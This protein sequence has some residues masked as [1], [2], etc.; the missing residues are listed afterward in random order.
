MFEETMS[1]SST[2]PLW[3]VESFR[4]EMLKCS[5]TILD[6]ISKVSSRIVVRHVRTL[7]FLLLGSSSNFDD[8]KMLREQIE[9]AI[10]E[11]L[12]ERWTQTEHDWTMKQFFSCRGI[13]T[14]IP[15][16]DI[17]YQVSHNQ[18]L[19]ILLLV[20]SMLQSW[21]SIRQNQQ[22]EINYEMLVRNMIEF[23]A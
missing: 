10:K 2:L 6:W 9:G 17:S 20:S 21:W 16:H 4:T 14:C 22:Q 15:S 7:S 8:I 5:W 3:R 13:C 18:L 23:S 12:Q 19:N 1:E 11:R